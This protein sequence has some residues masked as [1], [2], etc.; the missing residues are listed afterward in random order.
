MN[1]C[2]LGVRKSLCAFWCD[3]YTVIDAVL[4]LLDI[5]LIVLKSDIAY[6]AAGR[7]GRTVRLVR[8]LRLLRLIK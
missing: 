1:A 7:A 4:V 5:A 3:P 8:L 6:A 2:T